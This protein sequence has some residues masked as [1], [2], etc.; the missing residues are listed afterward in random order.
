MELLKFQQSK[1]LC[2]YGTAPS[3]VQKFVTRVAIEMHNKL[4]GEEVSKESP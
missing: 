1:S 4:S 3:R 2:V